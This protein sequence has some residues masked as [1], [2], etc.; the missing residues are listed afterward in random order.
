MLDLV[1]V[2]L[3]HHFIFVQVPHDLSL[4]GGSR[5]IL[6]INLLQFS[7]NFRVQFRNQLCECIIFHLFLYMLGDRIMRSDITDNNLRQIMKKSYLNALF[8]VDFDRK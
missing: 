2:G 7:P 4:Y 3:E 1:L 8:F 5:L 6:L